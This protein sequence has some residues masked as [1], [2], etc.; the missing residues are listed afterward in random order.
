[1]FDF[2]NADTYSKGVL[3]IAS[4]II[5]SSSLCNIVAS[6]ASDSSQT[7]RTIIT[8]TQSVTHNNSRTSFIKSG[9][10]EH[11]LSRYYNMCF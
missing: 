3:A 1:M 11:K 10:G 8:V 6:V 9:F 2:K 4:T 7:S 5:V